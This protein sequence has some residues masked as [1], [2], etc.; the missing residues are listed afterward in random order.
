MDLYERVDRDWTL[1]GGQLVHLHCAERGV[2]TTR[3]TNDVDTVV[4]IRTAPAA[5][6]TFTRALMDPGFAAD[7]SGDGVQH[8]WRRDLAQIDVLIPEGVGQRA[9]ARAGAAGAPTVASPGSTQALARSEAV[10]VQ[11]AS[12][13]GTVLRPN[14]VGALVSKA[15]ARTEITSDWA[16]ARHC[17]DF[18]VLASLIAARDFRE[19]ELA[20]KDRSRL[21]TMVACCRTDDSAMS[22]EYAAEALDRLERAAKLSS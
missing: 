1:I 14:L 17:T 4:D 8:R 10:A 12:R 15:A 2:L 19:T 3:P 11:A 18:L 20:S 9:A 13:T 21:R 16:R 7:I 6:K 22:V 5:L